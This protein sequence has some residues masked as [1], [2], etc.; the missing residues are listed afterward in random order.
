MRRKQSFF[1]GALVA[2]MGIGPAAPAAGRVPA[3]AGSSHRPWTI[4]LRATLDARQV[5]PQDFKVARARGLFTGT[6]TGKMLT[7]RLTYSGLSGPALG[8]HIHLGKAGAYKWEPVLGLCGFLA[9]EPLNCKPGVHGTAVVHDGTFYAISA[10]HILKAILDGGAYVNIHTRKNYNYG[11]IRG[12]IEV[13][14]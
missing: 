8:A 10:K 3:T 9:D 1:I 4:K 5:V 13:V 2:L 6:L 14:K 11:E 12:Q 7:W